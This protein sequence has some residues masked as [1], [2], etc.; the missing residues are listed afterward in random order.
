MSD[1]VTIADVARQ[2]GVSPMTVSRVINNKGDVRASTRQ[3]V[4]AVVEQLGYR[5]S[6]IARGLATRRTG[7]LGL[8]VP[9]VANPF[10]AD[11]VRGVEHGAYARGYNVFLCN[12]E[13]DPQRELEILHLLEEKQVEGLVLCSSRL[14]APALHALVARQSRVVLVNRQLRNR[15][16]RSVTVDDEK[17]GY[18]ATRHLLE[19]GRRAVGLL[20]GPEPSHSGRLRARG[21]RAALAEFRAPSAEAWTGPCR[22]DVEG[23]LNAAR[24]LLERQPQLDGLVCFNDL[25]AV[26]AL[27]ACAEMG[28]AV[29]TDMAIVG[30]DDIALAALVTPSLTTCRVPRYELG[31]QAVRLLLEQLEGSAEPAEDVVLQPE[32]IIRQS[33]PLVS[34]RPGALAAVEES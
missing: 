13:E 20:A 12:S 21:Y 15:A 7:A 2:A 31:R 3:R 4:M 18:L 28:R 11:L 8:V 30:Y 9:D 17:G 33:A 14:D 29:P 1:R 16:V 32:L 23:G 22:P 24:E 6:S 5:P 10:F 25:V 27:Q 19:T 26:G 34:K